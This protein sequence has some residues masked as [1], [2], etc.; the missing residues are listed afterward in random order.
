MDKLKE[1]INERI[2]RSWVTTLIGLI[3]LMASIASHFIMG[4]A[5]LDLIVPISIGFILL[6]IKEPKKPGGAGMGFMVLIISMLITGCISFQKCQD[7]FGSLKT[8]TIKV[9]RLVPLDFAY[10]PQLET[11]DFNFRLDSLLWAKPGDTTTFTNP[12]STVKIKVSKDAQNDR[13]NIT[14]DCDPDTIKVKEFVPV[15]IKVPCETQVFEDKPQTKWG[16]GWQQ[17]KN[18]SAFAFPIVILLIIILK[19]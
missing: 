5:W 4:V 8:D 1:F 3:F 12:G 15:E 18:V 9:T 10:K 16:K 7:K 2:K 6:P 19:R 14:A 11:Y 17:Y 13:L